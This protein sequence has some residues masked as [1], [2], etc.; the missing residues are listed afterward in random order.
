MYLFRLRFVV[1]FLLSALTF[2]VPHLQAQ[3]SAPI[4]PIVAENCLPGTDS[5]LWDIQSGGF[6]DPTIQ[7]FASDISVNVSG[8]VYF[9]IKT[10]AKAYTIDIYRMGYYQGNGARKVASI[11][12]SI[13][14]PQSQPA[15]ITDA[16][17]GL[18]DCGNWAVSASWNVP[19]TA[20]SG[21]YFAHLIRTDTGGD[22]HIVFV[23]RND[24]N[25]SDILFQT[26]DET[27]QAYNY[28]GGGSLYGPNTDSFNLSQRAYKVSYNR[29]FYTRGFQ[30]EAASWVF[31]AEYPMVRWLEAN[32]YNVSYFT[33]LDAARYGNLITNHRAYLT[34]GH[35]EYWSGPQRTNVQAA[36]DAG[37]NMAFF[38]GNETFWKTR[39]ENSIDGT[40]TA[41]RTLV[42]Y[43]ETLAFAPIDPQDPNTWTGT[44]RD[45]S[46]SPPADG[47]QPENALTGTLFMVNGPAPDNPGTLA[48]TI[49]AA[50]GK[51]RFWRNTAVANLASGATYSLPKSTLGYEWDVDADNGS[52]PAGAF[53][54]STTT[55][56]LTTDYLLD[57]GATYGAGTATHNLMMYRAA[58]GAL[59]FGA[60]TIQWAWGLDEN[61]DDPF[62]QPNPPDPNMQQATINLLADMGVQ[63]ATLQ[64]GLVA[65][66]ASTDKTPPSSTILS[67]TP[68]STLPVDVPTTI[69]GTA[70]DAGGGV[71]AG[72]EV[73]I[74]GG[75]T[76]HPATGRSNWSYSVIPEVVGSTTI[77][78]RAAD[79]SGNIETPSGGTT[80]Y[81][82]GSSAGGVGV[83]VT[84]HD[85]PCATWPASTVPGTL[86]SGDGNSVELGVKFQ[87]DYTG[88]ITG[89]RFY[90]STRNTGTHVGNLWTASGTL[91]AS[92]TFTNETS[93]GWQQ[94]NFSTPVAIAA[95]TTYIA[96]YFAPAGHYSADTNYF[97]MSGQDNPPVHLLAS[98]VG[99]SNGL[100]S[101]GTSPLLPT[102]GYSA[103]N[104]WVDLVFVPDTSMADAPPA[105][106][107]T[108]QQLSF[109][110]Y[111]GAAAPASQAVTVYNEGTG[112]LNWTASSSAPWLVL[113]ATS[114]ATPQSLAVSV[115]ATGLSAGTYTGTITITSSG[116]ANAPQTIQV[117]LTVTNLLLSAN[118]V[119]QGS[120]GWV[121]SPL[122]A[123]SDW[124]IASGAYNYDGNGNSQV[125]AGNSGWTDYLVTATFQL[126][127]MLDWP[128]GIRGRVNPSTGAG[129]MV[130]V[131]PVL[132][133]IILFKASAWDINQ[134][135]TQLGVAPVILDM[136]T[137][138]N[139][140]LS[141]SGSQIQVLYDGKAIITQTDSTY[142][143]GVVALEGDNQVISFQ[144][145]LVTSGI[146]NTGSI[147]TGTNNLNFSATYGVANPAPQTVA[148][149][150]AGSGS[151]VWSASSSVPW[152]SISSTGGTTPANLQV[153]ASLSSLAPGTY[154]GAISI[155]SLGA[156]NVSQQ[157]A[158]SFTV[159]ALPPSLVSAPAAMIFTSTSG[160]PAAPV[161]TLLISNGGYGTFGWTASSDSNWLSVTSVS[162]STPANVSVSV[163]SSGLPTGT[164]HGNLIIRA[165]GVANSPLSVPITLEVLAQDMSETFS[166]LGSGWI[167][168]PM[169]RGAG[170]TVSNGAYS[171]GGQG[172]SQSCSGNAGWTDYTFDANIKL[173]TLSNWPGGVRARVNPA[174]GAGYVVWVYPATGM[175]VLF[176][177]G[178][179]SIDGPVLSELAQAN[180]SFDT[181][182]F[183]DLR[184]AFQGSNIAVSWDGKGLMSANDSTYSSGFV[185][186]DADNQAISYSNIQ[187]AS[188]QNQVSLDPLPSSILFSASP[189]S[190]PV[191]QTLN[192]TAAGATTA[193]AFTTNGAS[194]L[195]ASASATLTPGS[196][197]I[198]ANA[199]G[200]SEGT[201]NGSITVSVPG[202]SNS[203]ITIPVKLA[204][205]TAVL[206]ATPGSLA[207]FGA[208]TVS[209]VAQTI[210]IRNQGSG[211]LAWSASETSNW[212]GLSSVSGTAP[213]TISVQPNSTV[214]ATGSYSDTVTISSPDVPNSPVT[215]PASLQVG[216]LLFSD[217]FS[218]GSGNWTV[219]PLGS[220]SGWSVSNGSYIF[221]GEGAT[222]SWAGSATWTNYT[223]TADFQL[224]SLND[225]PGGIRG[226]LNP[227]TGASYGVWIYPA[228]GVLKLFR[229]DQWDINASLALIAQSGAVAMD[230]N[231][232]HLRLIFQGSSIQVYYDNV[233]EMTATDTTYTQGAVALD[234]SN[235]PIAFT[236]VQVIGF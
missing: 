168:S 67:P 110:A 42:C 153:S 129:Y 148:I 23:V 131:Y 112:T 9:K 65:G 15:C 26:N 154:S 102:H 73:S 162:G 136:A 172:L 141:F 196:L 1:I 2:Y 178:Q 7:G 233:L 220:A 209:P 140:S 13:P 166:D 30:E 206:S 214:L 19:A 215:V 43:K 189:G 105:L 173:S 197:T 81:M 59:V 52:R 56:N 198:T 125:F 34:S 86:D 223:V 92:A 200:L 91:L 216:T 33:G 142:A 49:P 225:W 78:S 69:T 38:S 45:R 107:V 151:L 146:P 93:T 217:N 61:H 227:N 72:V 46:F 68:G 207:F 138:H 119:N 175:I 29:P 14:L 193:W 160:Q 208:T 88:Y 6:G 103:T 70:T 94:V 4:N 171:Y 224:S 75:K 80:I 199:A 95:N 179:W 64:S 117:S 122:G 17:T 219:G 158:V 51:M 62:T 181:S 44:W 77:L 186:L 11:T 71:V 195:T 201:Y 16:S 188:V 236:N 167:I 213:S 222:Q 121:T 66:V 50:D 109:A 96:S 194:W 22:S 130:W 24:S 31:G 99:S 47:G 118:F 113:A 134:P 231:A 235:Q 115:N 135:L 204:V 35:D 116:A 36:R 63:P 137:T 192:V 176:K 169:G 230:T 84:E 100:Y 82:S 155:V 159:A 211:T 232:H 164:Y 187:I 12:P 18:Y 41:Y 221:N 114:G 139:L 39:W 205:T 183:H 228:Q 149:S 174:T 83:T 226:R 203:P 20:T 21:I 108:N 202:A 124:S 79:D 190:A 177:I 98:G 163:N 120:Q 156:V 97:S 229:I 128:G 3:C 218:A 101:Y 161:Q 185:C 87:T 165:Q 126:S 89:I 54:L 5:S 210:Q 25:T 145:V 133:E 143:G 53:H 147:T 127:N 144:Q 132:N 55:V 182:A 152:L 48:I 10:N 104:Y 8:T 85:C 90:K 32:G 184:I 60:G 123:A 170:W 28:Y 111:V 74:D 150:A 40:G 180:L 27:W 37:V 106:L 76:W 191:P 58:S 212:L 57:W 157:I 234:V